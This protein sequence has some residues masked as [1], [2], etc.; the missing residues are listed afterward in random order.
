ME[1]ELLDIPVEDILKI[2]EGIEKKT[3]TFKPWVYFV[4]M[5]G[6][7]LVRAVWMTTLGILAWS[8]GYVI[9][10]LIEC[11]IMNGLINT[12]MITT[13][14]FVLTLL[15]VFYNFF[16]DIE[17]PYMKLKNA[18]IKERG[19]LGFDR[20]L[21]YR[22]W[23]S[24][25]E[26]SEIKEN[27]TVAKDTAYAYLIPMT[28]TV[29]FRISKLMR[30]TE[31]TTRSFL[32]M[33][34]IVFILCVIYFANEIFNTRLVLG[35]SGNSTLLAIIVSTVLPLISTIVTNLT[36]RETG[37]D[38]IYNSRLGNCLR[39]LERQ[40]EKRNKIQFT[41]GGIPHKWIPFKYIALSTVAEKKREK[42]DPLY[43]YDEATNTAR[44]LKEDIDRH[45]QTN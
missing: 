39:L 8:N 32:Q 6:N 30:V 20:I 25:V 38:N 12:N 44:A 34:L 36:Q 24:K 14:S 16:D 37:T 3:A 15:G 28:W 7:Q 23:I 19:S 1:N 43:E 13:Y 29:F 2:S 33:L 40:E 41:A 5:V 42:M 17:K 4:F 22:S 35:L 18:I 45:N 10:R 21:P 9:T 11:T 31:A 27:M 26:L